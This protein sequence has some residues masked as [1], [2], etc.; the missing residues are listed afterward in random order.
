LATRVVAASFGAAIVA[1]ALATAAQ[2]TEPG[3]QAFRD[4]GCASC[5]GPSAQGGTAPA[6]RGTT[7]SYPEFLRIVR[8]G[9]DE[10][11]ARPASELS[12][13]QVATIHEWLVQLPG[14][15]R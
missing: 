13:E 8:D 10:M 14:R 2:Q 1:G 6:L 4:A 9:F 5:H 11:P 12:D 15:S 3:R 7:R